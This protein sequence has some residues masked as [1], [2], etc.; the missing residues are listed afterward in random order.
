MYGALHGARVRCA[1]EEGQ[2]DVEGGPGYSTT[3][4]RSYYLALHRTLMDRREGD[5]AARDGR[6]LGRS[7]GPRSLTG[8]LGGGRF[9]AE[10]PAP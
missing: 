9:E 7:D 1:R 5:L 4:S 2:R 8:R 6:V 3:D 10:L